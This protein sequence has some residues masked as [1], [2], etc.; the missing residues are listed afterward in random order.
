MKT[1][2][3]KCGLTAAYNREEILDALPTV[4]YFTLS[5]EASL[6]I[7]PFNQFTAFFQEKNIRVVSFD[8][9]YH[10]SIETFHT[11]IEKWCAH[12]KQGQ[13]IL[14]PY[15]EKVISAIDELILKGIVDKD[16]ISIAGLSRGAFVACHIASRHP[17]INKIVGF[18]P[19]TTLAKVK[20][21]KDVPYNKNLDLINIASSLIGKEL[22]FYIGNTDTRVGV[23]SCFEFINAL[24]FENHEAKIRPIKVE[25]IIQASHGHLGHGT[26]APTFENGA[27]W[28]QK[29]IKIV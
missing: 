28:I 1:I 27:L 26:L 29:K 20:E 12:F 4:F 2:D 11:A 22:R 10:S 9:P 15:F 5:K 21:F 16:N 13:D 25:L 8:L 24:S 7:D 14:T 18:A 6:T 23:E 3:L 17:L 19:L